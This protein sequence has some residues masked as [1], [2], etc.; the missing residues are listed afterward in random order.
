MDIPIK[1]HTLLSM[2]TKEIEYNVESVKEKAIDAFHK[3]YQHVSWKRALTVV[4]KTELTNPSLF[5]AKVRSSAPVH[6]VYE[7]ETSIAKIEC[8][9]NFVFPLCLIVAIRGADRKMN[10]YFETESTEPVE[11]EFT[12]YMI[13]SIYNYKSEIRDFFNMTRTHEW[14]FPNYAFGLFTIDSFGHIIEANKGVVQ[15]PKPEEPV[16]PKKS[17]FCRKA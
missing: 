12:E 11:V 16:K 7:D 13:G 2:P 1:I 10:V 15:K 17:W 6:F 3:G 4:G 14:K 8:N 5:I 9:E